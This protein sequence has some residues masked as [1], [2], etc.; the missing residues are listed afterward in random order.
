M[1]TSLA[2]WCESQEVDTALGPLHPWC[3]SFTWGKKKKAM[4]GLGR[5]ISCASLSLP[6]LVPC[7]SVSI[8]VGWCLGKPLGGEDH[9]SPGDSVQAPFYITLTIEFNWQ[10][11]KPCHI[12][13]KNKWY[14]PDIWESGRGE[15]FIIF[16]PFLASLLTLQRLPEPEWC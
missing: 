12:S 8:T 14:G 5:V 13:I 3:F 15:D 11:I 16:S 2:S 6:K 7:W 1:L 4:L 10:N 9:F